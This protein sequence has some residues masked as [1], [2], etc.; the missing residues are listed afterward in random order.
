MGYRTIPTIGALFLIQGL[1][2]ATLAVLLLLSRRLL[3]VVTATCFM[4]ATI[5]GLLLSVYFGL[6]GFMETLAAPYA[7]LSLGIEGAA[8]GVLMVVGIVLARG[9]SYSDKG[10]PPI[11]LDTLVSRDTRQGRGCMSARRHPSGAARSPH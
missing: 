9:R 2:G 8:A 4:I 5:S 10:H 7:G 6:F 3:I 1:A 11:H